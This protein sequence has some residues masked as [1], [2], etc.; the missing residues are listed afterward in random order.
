VA[1]IPPDSRRAV[2]DTGVS[3][4]ALGAGTAGIAGLYAAVE[5]A[6]AVATVRRALATGVGYL[7]TAPHYGQGLAEERLGRALRG[8]PRESYVLST[9]VGRVL[10][11]VDAPPDTMFVGAPAREGRFDFS[12]AGVRASLESSLE[13]LGV[14]RVDIAYLHDP[15]D[16]VDQALD[17]AYPELERLRDEGMVRAIG[18]GM[19]QS[20]VPTRFVTETDIDVVLLAG[21]FTLL[22]QSGLADLLPAAAERGRAVVIGGVYNSGLLTDPRPGAP[23]NYAPA[24]AA[25]VERARALRSVCARHGVP[26][27]AAAIQ[28][29][30]AHPAVVSVL[31]GARSVAE[32]DANLAAFTHPVPPALWAELTAEGLLEEGA[33]G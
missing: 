31:S 29:P 28:F 18:V 17:E 9:K 30:L 3:L 27:T 24:P 12:A 16:H 33:R 11:D 13:R 32:T 2:R 14:D 7:D 10:V 6:D 23:F 15:D 26:L 21:R 1:L 8:I 20:A 25:L 19:N 5:E 4:T 22:D